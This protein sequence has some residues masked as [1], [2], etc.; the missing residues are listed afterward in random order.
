M[1]YLKVSALEVYILAFNL[2]TSW[3]I[4]AFKLTLDLCEQF[5][6]RIW[7]IQQHLIVYSYQMELAHVSSRDSHVTLWSCLCLGGCCSYRNCC[8]TL[9]HSFSGCFVNESVLCISRY[10]TAITSSNPYT[11]DLHVKMYACM[12]LVTHR[13]VGRD[14]IITITVRRSCNILN[15]MNLVFV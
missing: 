7:R 15:V 14:D 1:Y 2:Q 10:E 5:E 12:L 4:C 11:V 13:K 8:I 6:R 9:Y 3:I